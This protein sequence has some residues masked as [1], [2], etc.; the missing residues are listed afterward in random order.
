MVQY[1]T[2]PLFSLTGR[3]EPALL[4]VDATSIE[5]VLLWMKVQ[6]SVWPDST[7]AFP[8]FEGKEVRHLERRMEAAAR[9][10]GHEIPRPTIFRRALENRNKREEGP[11]R[12]AISR[13]MSHSL[14][15]AQQYYQAPTISDTYKAYGA[16]QEI[17]G[18]TR[19]LS[20]PTQSPREEVQEVDMMVQEVDTMDTGLYEGKGKTKRKRSDQ[21]KN[22]E[23]PLEKKAAT[24]ARV[25]KE[26]PQQKSMATPSPTRKAFTP[27]QEDVLADYFA[28]HIAKRVFPTSVECRDFI[29]LHPSFAHRKPKDIYDKCR[30]IAGR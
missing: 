28:R 27:Q 18:G 22:D 7:L 26:A 19:G 17:I 6:E 25:N 4:V 21:G 15:T 12:E 23:T 2:S 30:N 11:M 3:R 29:K 9:T 10:V 16:V 5:M 14:A 24:T 20:P 8:D 1:F 13:S